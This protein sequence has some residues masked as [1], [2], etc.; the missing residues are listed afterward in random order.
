MNSIA[1]CIIFLNERRSF[2]TNRYN[3]FRHSSDEKE[4]YSADKHKETAEQFSSVIN[5]LDT[6]QDNEDESSSGIAVDLSKPSYMPVDLSTPSFAE[7]EYKPGKQEDLFSFSESDISALP[8][9]VINTLNL[10]KSNKLES[11]I[12]ELIKIAKRPLSVK[13]LI[14]ALYKK[15]NYEVLERNRFATKLYRMTHSGLLESIAGK[16]GYYGLP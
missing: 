2:H 1:D 14:I 6:P 15:Y 7:I 10:S 8:E 13:E 3:K 11:Q 4:K 5:Y 12:I 16:R 9:S